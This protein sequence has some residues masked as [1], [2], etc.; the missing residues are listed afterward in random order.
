LHSSVRD[1]PGVSSAAVDPTIADVLA[2]AGSHYTVVTAVAGGVL[3]LLQSLL[4]PVFPPFSGPP[5]VF[6]ILRMFAS[7]P[8]PTSLLLLTSL[9]LLTSLLLLTSLPLQSPFYR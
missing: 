5:A 7:L 9:P 3:L 1:V 4:F 8:L 2:A 6:S